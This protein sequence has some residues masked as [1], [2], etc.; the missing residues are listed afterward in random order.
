LTINCVLSFG[1]AAVSSVH[2]QSSA[3]PTPQGADADGAEEDVLS[4]QLKAD[5]E[6]F[7]SF[8]L[9]YL[10]ECYAHIA[11]APV[12]PD[13]TETDRTADLARAVALIEYADELMS[14]TGEIQFQFT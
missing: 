7:R 9:V 4:L 5:K 13:A 8:R 14:N 10:A 11:I 12:H 3:Q 1:F 2:S 6:I